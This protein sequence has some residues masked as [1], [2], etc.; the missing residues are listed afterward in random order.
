MRILALGE[1]ATRARMLLRRAD[2][3]GGGL[4]RYDDVVLDP[5]TRTARRGSRDL[6]LT[7]TEFELLELLLRNA[8]RV[9]TRHEILTQVWGFDFGSG[10]NSLNVY[11]GYVRRKLGEPPLVHTVRGVGYMLRKP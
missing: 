6:E 7:R 2:R 10:S 4:L 11:I 5:A 1:L 8:G 9:V 3:A